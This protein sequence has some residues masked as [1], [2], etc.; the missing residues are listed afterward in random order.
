MIRQTS[1]FMFGAAGVLVLGLCVG[2]VAYYGSG[3]PTLTASVAG[4]EELQYIQADATI[5]AY[6]NIRDIM[7]SDF[8]RRFSGPRAGRRRTAGISAA[9]RHQPRG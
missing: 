4:P 7:L 9:D 2:L 8:R 6:A 5:V 3:L 1:Y